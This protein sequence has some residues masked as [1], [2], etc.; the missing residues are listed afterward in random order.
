[1]P[2]RAATHSGPFHA[3]DVLAWGLIQVF[4]DPDASL[5]RT[6]D[7][8]ILDASDIVFDVGGIFDPDAGRF[9]HHQNSYTGPLSSAGMVLNWLEASGR[10]PVA[11]ATRIRSR[12][13]NYV[14]DVD[15]GRR[16]TDPVVPCFATMVEAFNRGSKDIPEFDE[17]FARAGQMA[18]HF[19]QGIANGHAEEAAA[20]AVVQQA[21]TD[22][23]SR[24]SNTLLLNPYVRWKPAYF[25]LGGETDRTQFVIAPGPDGSWR[26]LAIPPRLGSFDQKQ[27][28]PAQWA[29]LV[30]DDL[31]EVCGVAGARFC[32]KNRFIMV[33]DT[34]DG[35]IE[36]MQRGDL[37]TGE[38]PSL[39]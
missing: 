32:H 16:E 19:V 38:A 2:I 31:V 22:A 5:V 28:L 39:S 18:A 8:R 17:A 6:R 14:D 7:A 10:V 25:Q 9:D 3:D 4:V 36:A 20:H 23:E 26:T 1:M 21:L 13:C 34:F 12:V 33:F 30:D 29:G 27:S 15:N 24:N 35:L 11:L 37:L